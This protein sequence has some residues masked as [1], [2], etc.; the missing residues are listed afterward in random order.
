MTRTTCTGRRWTDDSP[1]TTVRVV[2]GQQGRAQVTVPTVLGLTVLAG[3]RAADGAGVVLAPPD[4]DGPG[5]G[6]LLWPHEA[7]YVITSQSP[8]P[9]TVLRQHDSVVVE[10]ERTG[11]GGP[12]TA[13]VGE[14]RRPGPAPG[15]A[16]A[17]RA[18]D[19]PGVDRA[20]DR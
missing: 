20:V 1:R 10:Y 2:T 4:R 8:A 3:R 16:G 13:G 18:L 11:D 5:L 6:S 9:G 15:S 19:P 12:G 17:A 7:E 14:P